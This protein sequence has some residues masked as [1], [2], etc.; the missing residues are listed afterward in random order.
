MLSPHA[1][2]RKRSSVPPYAALLRASVSPVLQPVGASARFHGAH[3]SASRG[4]AAARTC[5]FNRLTP[6][7][8]PHYWAPSSPWRAVR[9][10]ISGMLFIR[11][12]PGGSQPKA[13]LSAGAVPD[14]SFPSSMLVM[15][16]DVKS[17]P[18]IVICAFSPVNRRRPP[19]PDGIFSESP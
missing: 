3:A 10:E 9:T 8:V 1:D 4:P 14:Y 19:L 7:H 17:L 15:S 11:P 12:P 2:R 13:A 6:G 18:L 5:S 16:G